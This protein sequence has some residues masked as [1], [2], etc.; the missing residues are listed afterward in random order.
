M[1]IMTAGKK[2]RPVILVTE[3]V[4]FESVLS[5][6]AKIGKVISGKPARADLRR[7]ISLCDAAVIRVETVIDREILS[8]ARNL[9]LIASATTGINH[10]D[11]ETARRR[12]VRIV[13][14]HGTHTAPTAEHALALILNLARRVAEVHEH[15]RRGRWDR[16]RWIG[17]QLAGRTI[18]I[19]GLGRIGGAVAKLAR[20]FGMNVLAYDPYVRGAPRVRMCRDL[21]R[22]IRQSDVVSIHAALTPKTCGMFGERMFR[23]FKRGGLLVNTAR[24]EIVDEPAL[25]RA[26]KTGQIGAAALDVYAAEPLPRSSPL[27]AYARRRGNLILTPHLGASTA[28]AV[29]AAAEEMAKQVEV[30]F[31][32]DS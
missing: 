5:R 30:F 11:A 7:K 8:R 2:P 31:G 32:Q 17:M 13:H 6:L 10:I 15:M 27:R 1:D 24:G 9:R 23:N 3:P 16:A 18:G 4:Y 26:L 20:A 28:Q 22:L 14:L 29:K 25:L 19:V 21:A 12:G